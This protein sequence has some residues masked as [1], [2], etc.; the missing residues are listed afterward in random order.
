MTVIKINLE[1]EFKSCLNNNDL[2]ICD[3]GSLRCQ[4]CRIMSP[5][6]EELSEKYSKALFIKI[7]IDELPTIADE[8]NIVSMPTFKIYLKGKFNLIVRKTK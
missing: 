3:Y 6:F 8:Q 1:S 4:P 5:I 2:V 7:D